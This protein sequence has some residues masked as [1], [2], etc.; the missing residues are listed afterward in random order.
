MLVFLWIYDP[1]LQLSPAP[2]PRSELGARSSELV[3]ADE[4]RRTD[5]GGD[6]GGCGQGGGDSGD[7]G[8]GKKAG[9]HWRT[10]CDRG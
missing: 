3:L 9:D 7:G 6:A 1:F 5:D 4:A 10:R 2:H 8:G